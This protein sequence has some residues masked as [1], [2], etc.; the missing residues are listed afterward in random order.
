MYSTE[1]EE[2]DDDHIS[3]W[4]LVI[5]AVLLVCVVALIYLLA[6]RHNPSATPQDSETQAAQQLTPTAPAT[7]AVPPEPAPKPSLAEHPDGTSNTDVASVGDNTLPGGIADLLRAARS[8]N[9]QAQFEL[10]NA[11]LLGNGVPADRVSAYTWLTL[12]FANDNQQAESR[13]REL[14]R[15]L[16][17]SEIAQVRRN[18]GEMY[19]DGIGVHPDK[20][21]AYMWQL[22]AD[23]AG[24]TRSHDERDQLARSMTPDEI[25]EAQTRASEWLRKHQAPKNG[26]LPAS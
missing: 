24:D 10:G 16:N 13:I 23:S 26:N 2:R 17:A 9:P 18:L 19:A 25:A 7:A 8:G 20:V 11:Y 3:R 6:A 21:T 4:H 15:S 14:S 5:P 22:L 1:L 12:A